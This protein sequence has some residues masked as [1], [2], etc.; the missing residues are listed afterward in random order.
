[1]DCRLKV[2]LLWFW[3]QK[4]LQFACADTGKI[5]KTIQTLSAPVSSVSG[6]FGF[7]WNNFSVVLK[8]QV[9]VRWGIANRLMARWRS[10]AL[11][12]SLS[13]DGVTIKTLVVIKPYTFIYLLQINEF[14]QRDLNCL[15]KVW[16]CPRP[17][18][19]KFC[20]RLLLVLRYQSCKQKQGQFGQ[21]VEC[22]FTN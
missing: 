20:R 14:N 16:R 11:A 12:G 3:L 13:S 10:S 22:S 8:Y 18:V 17:P 5:A 19:E 2:L 1:M 9:G 6:Y 15:L 4:F 7:Q 21:M